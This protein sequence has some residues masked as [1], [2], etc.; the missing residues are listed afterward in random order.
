MGDY[1]LNKYWWVFLPAWLLPFYFFAF[2]RVAAVIGLKAALA[3]FCILFF[4][5]NIVV[6]ARMQG[7]LNDQQL[8]VWGLALPG[9]ILVVGFGIALAVAQLSAI[10]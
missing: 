8:L 7:K 5:T 2:S 10:L 1:R 9:A 4:S 6:I 3:G